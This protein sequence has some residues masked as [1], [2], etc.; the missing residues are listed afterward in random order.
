MTH[1]TNWRQK[2]WWRYNK[3]IFYK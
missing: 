2:I 1:K 3:Q